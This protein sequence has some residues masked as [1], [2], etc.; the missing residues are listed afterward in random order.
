MR[1]E[2]SFSASRG[3]EGEAGRL[4]DRV[5]EIGTKILE[6]PPETLRFTKAY[7][8]GNPG[9][10]FEESFRVEHDEAFRNNLLNSAR[11]GFA[12]KT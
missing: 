1:Q 7:L 5:I 3:R 11:E 4:L 10:S 12:R 9:K 2:F 8:S 6:A